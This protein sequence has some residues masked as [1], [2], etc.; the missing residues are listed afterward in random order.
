MP[1]GMVL[2]RD[3]MRQSH[4]INRAVSNVTKV[5]AEAVIIVL[6]LLVLI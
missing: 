6:E 4:F 5:L 2:N 3:V 1:D